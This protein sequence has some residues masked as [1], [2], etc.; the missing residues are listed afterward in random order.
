MPEPHQ[1]LPNDVSLAS[2]L[3]IFYS[4]QTQLATFH[5]SPPD[6]LPEPYARLLNH[7]GHMTVTV[8]AYYQDSVDV[9]VLR[10]QTNQGDYCREILLST[11]RDAK[12]VQYGIV[13]LHLELIPEP[14]RSEILAESKPLGRVLIDRQ[15][16]R[17]VELFD[18]FLIACGPKLSEL[19]AVPQGTLTYGRTA[20]IHCNHVPAIELLEIVA[21]VAAPAD[22]STENSF[23]KHL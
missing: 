16:L 2:L 3:A 21:P 7:A 15:I 6:Q 12:I 4:E 23:V 22:K 5:K 10:S 18:L 9:R 1:H 11:H 17:E 19:L 13:R 8:E 14:A 20:L